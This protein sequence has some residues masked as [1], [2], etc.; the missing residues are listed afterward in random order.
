[1]VAEVVELKPESSYSMVLLD[2]QAIKALWWK[3]IRPGLLKVKEKDESS[4]HWEPEHVRKLLEAGAQGLL[5]CQCHMVVKEGKPVGFVILR[6]FPDEFT[7]VPYDLFVWIGHSDDPKCVDW[8]FNSEYLENLAKDMG[9]SGVMWV[10]GREGWG[11]RASRYGFDM[12]QIVFRKK[13]M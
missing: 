4:G 13:V 9:L 3:E 1:M 12:K 2:L 5:F 8:V 7:Q 10:S 6:I 11:K